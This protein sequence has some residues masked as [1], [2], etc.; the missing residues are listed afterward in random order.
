MYLSQGRTYNFVSG[1]RITSRCFNYRKV[2]DMKPQ[3]LPFADRVEE[4]SIFC[5]PCKRNEEFRKAA[6]Y[7]V[8]CET[9]FCVSHQKLDRLLNHGDKYSLCHFDEYDIIYMYLG[10]CYNI[11]SYASY[12]RVQSHDICTDF[13][14]VRMKEISVWKVKSS[15]PLLLRSCFVGHK[16]IFM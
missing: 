16:Y 3:D 15:V 6:V 7:C 14:A 11:I 8:K 10:S 5:Q 13:S 4:M 1:I 9:K 12:L 2:Y